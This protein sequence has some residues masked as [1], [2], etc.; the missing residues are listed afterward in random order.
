S[1][2]IQCA[3]ISTGMDKVHSTQETIKLSDMGLTADLVMA[4]LT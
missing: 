1:L 2:G 4:I 3:I